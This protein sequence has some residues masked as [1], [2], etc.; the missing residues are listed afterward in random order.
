MSTKKLFFTTDELAA[1]WGV[2]NGTLRNWRWKKQGPP[3]HKLGDGD[4]AQVYYK[5]DDI[6]KY[7]K[8]HRVKV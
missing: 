1:R 3:H 2:T 7:E 8:S 5:I 4:R 6:L